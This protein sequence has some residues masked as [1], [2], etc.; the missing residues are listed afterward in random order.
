[1]SEFI[2]KESE[3]IEDSKEIENIE[4]ENNIHHW[5]D[6]NISSALLRGIYSYGFETPSEIQKKAIPPILKGRD[7]IA[8][9]QSGSGKTGC[10][11]I[12]SLNLVDVNQCVVQAVIIV[13]THELANQI[14]GVITAIGSFMEGLRVKTIIGGTSI[15]KDAAD[16]KKNVPHIVVGCAGRIYDMIARKHL[17]MASLKLI[18][19]DEAD[20][21]LSKGFKDQIYNIFQQ[22]PETVQ[23]ALFSAT[24]PP[25]ILKLTEKFMNDPY[26]IIV[27]REELSVVGI[28]QY[29]VALND[30]RSKY[31]ALKSMFSVISVSQ[32][33]IYCNSVKKVVDLHAAMTEDGFSVCCIHGSMTKADRDVAFRS[34]L[35]GNYRVLISSDVTSR[36]I[37]IQ[38]VQFVINFDICKDLST[39]LHRVGRTSRYGR[40]GVAI[41]FITRGDLVIMKKIETQYKINIEELPR[42]YKGL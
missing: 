14:Y 36:G 41:N 5:D 32:C 30:D 22:F 6:L 2:E 39:F 11:S 9:A 34:F 27:K 12:S 23:V 15:Q 10:F 4:D 20:E 42:D 28:K 29:F 26:K 40:K 17:S 3:Y 37:D 1:M 31:D 18:V 24:L 16:I 13:P 25:E 33:I 21:M 38:Q 8:Q 7:I 35:D 19:L